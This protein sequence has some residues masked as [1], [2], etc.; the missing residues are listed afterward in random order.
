MDQYHALLAFEKCSEEFVLLVL[1]KKYGNLHVYQSRNNGWVNYIRNRKRKNTPNIL[2]S[3]CN[4][5]NCDEH[6]LV[7]AL[8]LDRDDCLVYKID[9]STM[10]YVELKTLGD[11]AL[12]YVSWKSCKSLSNPNRWGYESNS[13]Y[14]VGFPPRYYMVYNWESCDI[15]FLELPKP[16]SLKSTYDWCCNVKYEVD[17]SLVE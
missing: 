8:N 13:V 6:L 3:N 16:E 12:F 5:V 4:L 15:K 9:L 11:I 2:F 10:S 7:V 14:E 1:C 17:Y